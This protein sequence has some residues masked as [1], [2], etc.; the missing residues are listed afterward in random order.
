MPLP[1]YPQTHNSPDHIVVST[2][3]DTTQYRGPFSN[4]K[5]IGD[6]AS[7]VVEVYLYLTAE[8][9]DKTSQVNGTDYYVV[10]AI[11]TDE[12]PGPIYGFRFHTN[13]D[14]NTS[15]IAARYSTDIL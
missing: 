2:Q 7:D 15:L 10:R 11:V 8:G 4:I 5:I 3:N 1:G 6:S 9:Y 12:I 14:A 13:S